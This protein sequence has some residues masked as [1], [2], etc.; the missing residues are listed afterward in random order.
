MR[1]RFAVDEKIQIALATEKSALAYDARIT[2]SEGAEF[3]NHFGRVVYASSHGFAG[4]YAGS[5]FGHSV[6]AGGEARRRDAARLLVFVQSRK[7]A[8]LESPQ[9]RR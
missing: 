9:Q 4:E 8:N 2:N 7:F 1:E 6:C 5:T 3:S